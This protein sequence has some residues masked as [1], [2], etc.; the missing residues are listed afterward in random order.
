MATSI[1]YK[2]SELVN[3]ESG[4]KTLKTSGKYCED[5]IIVTSTG[6]GDPYQKWKGYVS[7]LSSW[8][9]LFQN[10]WTALTDDDLVGLQLTN[11]SANKTSFYFTF[12]NCTAITS[13]PAMDTTSATNMHSMFENCPY[14]LEIK[15]LNTN[16]VTDFYRMF[17]NCDRLQTIDF[18]LDTSHG[19]DLGAM[20]AS[21][22]ALKN[23][24]FR[25]NRIRRDISF[26]N[27]SSLTLNS[28]VSI[29]NGLSEDVTGY[30]LTLH[31]SLSAN[32]GILD[33]TT[34]TYETIYEEYDNYDIFTADGEPVQGHTTLRQFIT[35]VKGWGVI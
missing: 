19:T 8:N 10:A 1:T 33:T 25:P 17:R 23:V 3:F 13:M 5:D 11:Y 16:L 14:L 21:C 12:N 29:A 35:N 20:F 34:G 7:R 30:Y 24:R 22:L 18:V 28:L 4:T 15:G 6:G 32:G 2:G 27:S 31:T 26:L 9:N